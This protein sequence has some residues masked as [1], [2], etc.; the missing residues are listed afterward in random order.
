VKGR[1]YQPIPDAALPAPLGV[2]RIAREWMDR[3]GLGCELDLDFATIEPIVQ[4][5]GRHLWR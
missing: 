1:P 2:V 4:H 5:F 3:K